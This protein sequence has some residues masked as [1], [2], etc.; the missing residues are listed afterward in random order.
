M[1]IRLFL[2]TFVTFLFQISLTRLFGYILAQ[3]FTP[4]CISIALFGLGCG[5][6]IRLLFCE[7]VESH[8]IYSVGFAVMGIS[9]LS[10]YLSFHLFPHIIGPVVFALAFFI[11]SGALISKFYE[12]FKARKAH[13]AYTLDMA[14]GALACITVVPLL[15]FSGPIVIT[16]GASAICTILAA[17]SWRGAHNRLVV[18]A[19]TSLAIGIATLSAAIHLRLVEEFP[20]RTRFAHVKQLTETMAQNKNSSIV[21]FEW[22]SVG[23]A[24]L[25]ET[26]DHRGL[27]FIFYDQMN[28]SVM[29][30]EVN[31]KSWTAFP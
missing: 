1:Y 9:L 7:K 24:D 19:G 17:S 28:P 23:R 25:L 12:E 13:L 31:E 11:A 8:K 16:V 2:L 4:I 29:L 15:D 27:K 21:D 30:G 22:S 3:N 10:V 18:L 6:F 5:A 20:D 14:G 26:Q